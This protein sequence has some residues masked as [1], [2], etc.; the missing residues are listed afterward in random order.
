MFKFNCINNIS[1]I[2]LKNFN[3]LYE[4]TDAADEADG[5]LVRSAS[6]HEME[7]SDHLLCIARA[8]AGEIGRAHV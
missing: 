6:L 3:G 8:G 5:L 7:F 1:P 2:G 4:Q